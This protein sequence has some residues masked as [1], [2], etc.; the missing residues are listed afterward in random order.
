MLAELSHR[1]GDVR[2]RVAAAVPELAVGVCAPARNIPCRELA[3]ASVPVDKLHPRCARARSEPFGHG[4]RGLA[5]LGT[6]RR[7]GS[8]WENGDQTP[9]G[10]HSDQ[11][12]HSMLGSNQRWTKIVRHRVRL[13]TLGDL[14][15]E[16]SS[17]TANC[18]PSAPNSY[19]YDADE[20]AFLL[21]LGR[22]RA[23]AIRG[24]SWE[25]TEAGGHRWRPGRHRRGRRSE[26]A[27]S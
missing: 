17:G 25:L 6:G 7:D 16:G 18:R 24:Q 15:R 11:R 13:P 9:Q 12:Q 4:S 20:A 14:T 2:R 19:D 21:Y 10:Q 5:G 27:T 1:H 26:D 22:Y 8:E 23:P 3:I